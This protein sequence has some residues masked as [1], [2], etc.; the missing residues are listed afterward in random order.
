MSKLHFLVFLPDPTWCCCCHAPKKELILP[1][2]FRFLFF[3]A[4]IVRTWVIYTG[5]LDLMA[6]HD[7][8]CFQPAQL[9]GFPIAGTLFFPSG[10]ISLSVD[11]GPAS[12]WGMIISSAK[13]KTAPLSLFYFSSPIRPSKTCC[14]E[15]A[16]PN[17]KV[18]Q[19]PERERFSFRRK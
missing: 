6:T 15:W 1:E 5:R 19:R 9:C 10:F 17:R 2:R 7:F 3:L 4:H 8:C 11:P 12:T 14:L 13:S 18:S 16:R